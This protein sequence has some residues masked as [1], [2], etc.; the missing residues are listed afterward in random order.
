MK[1]IIL[2]F[3]LVGTAALGSFA[4]AKDSAAY[5]FSLKQ[6]VDYALQNQRDVKNALLDQE[7]AKKKVQEIA[8][9]GLPQI[10]G[11]FDVKRFV[12]GPTSIIDAGNFGGPPGQYLAANFNLPYQASGGF[13]ASQLLFSSDYFLGLKAS[14]VYAELSERATQRTRI[15]TSTT[16]SKAYYTVLINEER[17]KMMDATIVRVKK[18]MDDTKAF[19]DQ[20]LV[21][22]LDHDRLSVAYNNLMVEREKVVRLLDLGKYLLKYQMG[23]DINA[24]LVLTDKLDD[25]K[26]DP[27]KEI[28]AE[29]FDYTKRVEYNLFETQYN[30]AKLDVKRNRIAFLPTAVAYGTLSA[31][32]MRND[33]DVFNS[34]TPWYPLAVVGAKLTMPIFTGFRGGSRTQQA[35][36]KM[37]QA[38]NNIEFIRKS[39]D[40]ELSASAVNLQNASISLENQKKNIATAEDV[41]R[42][43]KIKYEQGV[44]SNLEMITAE[45]A[46]K[47]SQ[48]N[49][50]NALFD[51]VIA[52]LDF[53]KATGNIK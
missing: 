34:S 14:K 33:F 22:K 42:V 39:I 48:T 36:I 12:E 27:A 23:M 40:L 37:M 28:S 29:K 15:E 4:Q 1:R 30:L 31:N 26:L 11:S 6:A 52:K 38:E 49:Y 53:D 7:L 17:I 2:I 44:G 3:G 35:R 51:A 24:N 25:I 32:A 21:E 20:G 10:N 18:T 8:G 41:A 50:Y 46:L 19:L 9:A 13:D 43:A 45:T 16:V 47:E 5:S